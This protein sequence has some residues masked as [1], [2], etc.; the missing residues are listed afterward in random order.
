VFA[1]KQGLNDTYDENELIQNQILL[2][3]SELLMPINRSRVNGRLDRSSRFIGDV[4]SLSPV[5]TV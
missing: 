3:P 1:Y 2:G 5:P 4:G